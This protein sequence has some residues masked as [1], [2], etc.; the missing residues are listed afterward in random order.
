MRARHVL[1]GALL[2]LAACGPGSTQT[3]PTVG[4]EG[5]DTTQ[6]AATASVWAAVMQ[7]G[8]KWTM[9]S[10]EI[11]GMEGSALHAETVDVQEV[12]G[13]KIISLKWSHTAEGETT[14]LE[15]GAPNR[16]IVGKD[17][18]W[19]YFGGDAESDAAALATPAKYPEPVAERVDAE[20][21][22]S[23]VT[24]V[25][26]ELTACFGEGPP[27]DS[28]AECEDVCFAEMCIGEK[29]GIVAVDGTWAPDYM[30]F[31]EPGYRGA[32]ILQMQ[33]ESK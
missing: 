33:K 28:E 12:D 3:K 13:R 16:I 14:E 15:G 2:T 26:G 25:D 32:W 8:G 19:I 29:S 24:V 17:G 23:H 10:E 11:E 20:G 31:S 18:V 22:Y 6:P 21:F 1:S 30:M 27:P 9:E 5:G 4:N 7:P